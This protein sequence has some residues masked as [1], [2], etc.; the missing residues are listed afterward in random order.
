MQANRPFGF[1]LAAI[2]LAGLCLAILYLIEVYGPGSYTA[3]GSASIKADGTITV[4][5]QTRPLLPR[6]A[7]TA[8]YV[9]LAVLPLSLISFF[10]KENTAVSMA[11]LISGLIPVFV[12]TISTIVIATIFFGLALPMTGILIY[13]KMAQHKRTSQAD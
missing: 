6:I 2:L 9:C 5:H 3:S 13:R 4:I 12:M 11:A 1:G 7:R 8:F 10:R